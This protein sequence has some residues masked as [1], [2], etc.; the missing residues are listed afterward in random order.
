MHSNKL[1][2]ADSGVITKVKLPK[3]CSSSDIDADAAGT[4]D[5]F[6]AKEMCAQHVVHEVYNIHMYNIELLQWLAVIQLHGEITMESWRMVTFRMTLSSSQ[7]QL[8]TSDNDILCLY[9]RHHKHLSKPH[10][11]HH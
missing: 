5:A 3:L 9:L 4:S 1:L 8:V 6:T 11:R 10:T 2:H 7:R